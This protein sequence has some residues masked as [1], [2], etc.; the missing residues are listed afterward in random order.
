MSNGMLENVFTQS[1]RAYCA[2]RAR[3]YESYA[4][5]FCG[6]TAVKKAIKA[7]Y[8]VEINLSDIEISHDDRGV[9][10]ATIH[11]EHAYKASVSISHD[12]DR[13]IAVAVIE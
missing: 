13:A 12:G 1:E 9:P 7:A 6:K 3:P 8:Y 5:L 11:S 4:G 2:S 10:C